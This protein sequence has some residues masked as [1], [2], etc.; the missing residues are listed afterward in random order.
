MLF[1]MF[2]GSGLRGLSSIR[3]VRESVIRPVLCL[4]RKTIEAYLAENGL[5]CCQDST[6]EEDAYTRNRIRHHILPYAEREI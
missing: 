4:E 5:R 2:R 1:H 6:N 3:P